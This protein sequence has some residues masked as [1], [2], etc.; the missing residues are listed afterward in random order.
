MDLH[1]KKIGVRLGRVNSTG[2]D[3]GQAVNIG[4]HTEVGAC[5]SPEQA[6]SEEIKKSPFSDIYFLLMMHGCILH[7]YI[8]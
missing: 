6:S 7:Y 1:G 2:T 3:H 4:L 8:T 5:F